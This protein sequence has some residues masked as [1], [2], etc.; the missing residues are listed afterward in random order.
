[1]P[2]AT[3]FRVTIESLDRVEFEEYDVLCSGITGSIEQPRTVSC[4][5]ESIPN[6]RFLIKVELIGCLPHRTDEDLAA[7]DGNDNYQLRRCDKSGRESGTWAPYDMEIEV[8]MDGQIQRSTFMAL[9]GDTSAPLY[10]RGTQYPA[11]DEYDQHVWDWAFTETGVG[12]AFDQSE[13]SVAMRGT[14]EVR[15]RRYIRT[16]SSRDRVRPGRRARGDVPPRLHAATAD[17]THSISQLEY[18]SSSDESVEGATHAGTYP[19]GEGQVHVSFRFEY[20]SRANL[21]AL[22]FIDNRDATNGCPVS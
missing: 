18:D 14:I 4:K 15:P 16:H 9:D 2:V 17:G 1:M 21:E 19:D 11:D 6:T 22:G 12:R 3:E 5:I 20:V 10:I 8:Y 7:V 13:L